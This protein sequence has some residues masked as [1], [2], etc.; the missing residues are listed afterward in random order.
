MQWNLHNISTSMLVLLAS[1]YTHQHPHLNLKKS[2]ILILVMIHKSPQWFRLL[3]PMPTD[4]F[5][6]ILIVYVR[7]VQT[8]FKYQWE[9]R[10]HNKVGR[11]QFFRLNASPFQLKTF[12]IKN[13]KYNTLKGKDPSSSMAEL[14][15]KKIANSDQ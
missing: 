7:F 5:I 2:A 11:F 15:M 9:E 4:I 14:S 10:N 3:Q 12:I 8:M 1:I 13:M 6:V